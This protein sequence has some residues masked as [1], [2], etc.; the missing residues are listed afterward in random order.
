MHIVTRA[1]LSSVA[2]AGLLVPA[3]A[4][5]PTGPAPSRPLTVQLTPKPAA[6]ASFR[7]LALLDDRAVL[8]G[9][10]A[11]DE[12][13]VFLTQAEALRANAFRL[14]YTNAVS[15]LPEGS[16]ILVR[17]N[18]QTVGE[19]RLDSTNAAARAVIPIPLGVMTA[20][21]NAVRLVAQQRHRVDCSVNAT[22][23]L[24][25]EVNLAESGLIGL[26]A[27]AAIRR[28]ADLPALAAS[29]AEQTP[30]RLL[31]GEAPDTLTIDRAMRAA[32]AL[33]LAA[34][35]Q[36]PRIEL[37]HEAGE[38]L[39]IDLIVGGEAPSD[40]VQLESDLGLFYAADASG[41]RT[42]LTIRQVPGADIETTLRRMLDK[43]REIVPTGSNAGRRALANT[44]GRRATSGSSFSFAELG[45]ESRVFDGRLQQSAFGFSLPADFFAAPYG[46]ATLI[47][48][49]A[50]LGEAGPGK[51]ISIRVNDQLAAVVPIHQRGTAEFDQRRVELPMQMFKPG[52]NAVS[53]DAALMPA[54]RACDATVANPAPS[55]LT[56]NGSS[57]ISFGHLARVSVLPN[58]SATLTRGYPYAEQ[59]EPAAVAVSGSDPR[60]LSA[61]MTW[62]GQIT[63]SS[64]TPIQAA[65]RFGPLDDASETGLFFGPPSE[66]TQTLARHASHRLADARIAAPSLPTAAATSTDDALQTIPVSAER[67]W[68]DKLHL[69]S[70]VEYGRELMRG[71]LGRIT[72]TLQ[73]FGLVER[74]RAARLGTAVGPA[75]DQDLTV[76]QDVTLPMQSPPWQNLFGATQ[77]PP[78]RT[79]VLVADP[80]HIDS[81]IERATR[82]HFW[83]R[84][85]GESA[86][87]RQTSWGPENQAASQQAYIGSGDFSPANLRL[88]LA[89]WFAL[90]QGYYLAGLAALALLLALTT[91]A[92][93]RT[94]RL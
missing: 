20:G 85:N 21:Y 30:I 92:V 44:L 18:D 74:S 42:T 53:V 89:G 7:P 24:W 66:A 61:A 56:I 15:N 26:P 64:G 32:N 73:D 35:I 38:G 17:I 86:V 68:L 80:D 34:G 94:R 67:S 8:R 62:L 76:L 84:F 72:T 5:A 46:S 77:L 28:F 90:N 50:F 22:Y 48:D 55:R 36:R 47:L 14:V 54:D 23:E 93:L 88:T 11:S 27:A 78:I 91:A 6:E 16:R 81:L 2:L 10:L 40:S 4:Q 45:V 82:R 37:G 75:T 52:Y 31:I 3:Q 33:V 51:Q 13:A 87:V 29:G 12:R 1:L 69:S 79:M 9:E 83:T 63:A 25:S 70:A 57:R 71:D 41:G 59:A 43:A 49:S 39:G 65:F 58:L 19:A 60:Y